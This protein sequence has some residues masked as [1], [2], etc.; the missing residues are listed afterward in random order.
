MAGFDLPG[1]KLL[2]SGGRVTHQ[3]Y[4]SAEFFGSTRLEVTLRRFR[5]GEID[6][7]ARHL[8]EDLNNMRPVTLDRFCLPIR[9]RVE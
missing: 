1:D 5:N 8:C 3:F 2:L 4:T 7:A 9:Y 6:Y